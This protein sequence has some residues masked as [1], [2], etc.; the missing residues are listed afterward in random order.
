LH[1]IADLLP[2]SWVSGI[3]RLP[4]TADIVVT[5]DEDIAMKNRRTFLSG[6]SPN[7]GD[8]VPD[9]P[10]NWLLDEKDEE[11]DWDDEDFDDFDDLDEDEDE[12][13]EDDAEDEDF[14]DFDD[15]DE[16][17]DDEDWEDDDEDWE[18]DEDDEDEESE[19]VM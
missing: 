4:E 6:L 12:E 18:D 15:E 11:E 5:S 17:F 16:E 9:E 19:R 8:P 10:V 7:I 14:E 3:I 1:L 13:D 2:V